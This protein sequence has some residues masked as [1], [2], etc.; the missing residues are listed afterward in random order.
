MT[1]ISFIHGQQNFIF[2]AFISH[3][4]SLVQLRFIFQA[5]LPMILNTLSNKLMLDV[6]SR[7]GAVL[8][9]VSSI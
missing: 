2:S 9:G 3:S 5:A 1:D 6:G 8:Y 4:S 7:L